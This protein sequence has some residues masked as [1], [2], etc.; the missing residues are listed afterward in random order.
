MGPELE[1]KPKSESPVKVTLKKE[2]RSISQYQEEAKLN[3]D[4]QTLVVGKTYL[5]DEINNNLELNIIDKMNPVYVDLVDNECKDAVDISESSSFGDT[6]SAVENDLIVDVDEFQSRLCI[7]NTW[8]PDFDVY[9]DASRKRYFVTYLFFFCKLYNI[10][11]YLGS[12]VFYLS[13]P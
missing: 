7:D 3:F 5:P 8:V 4:S 2:N 11:L 9:L 12:S 1:L 13:N 6:T 10:S